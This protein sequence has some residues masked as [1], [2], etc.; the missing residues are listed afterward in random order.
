MRKFKHLECD[1]ESVGNSAEEIKKVLAEYA[2]VFGRS[3]YFVDKDEPYGDY[4]VSPSSSQWGSKTEITLEISRRLQRHAD[5]NTC[6]LRVIITGVTLQSRLDG[7]GM[8]EWAVPTFTPE[9]DETGVFMSLFDCEDFPVSEL[10]YSIE[11]LEVMLLLYKHDVA[12]NSG[13]LLVKKDYRIETTEHHCE[14]CE[15]GH[16]FYSDFD[17]KV[18]FP[19]YSEYKFHV[20]CDGNIQLIK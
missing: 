20:T 10:P 11:D 8:G 17:G 18:S 13:M 2:Y 9:G 14:N 7:I 4:S 19:D 5:N 16:C 3:T 1:L 6:R 12:D 15:G